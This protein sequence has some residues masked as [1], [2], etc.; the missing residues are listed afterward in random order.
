MPG[1]A[2]HLREIILFSGVYPL[3]RCAV[4]KKRKKNLSNAMC[5]VIIKGAIVVK[6]VELFRKLS[7]LFFPLNY[8]HIH[9][10]K[11]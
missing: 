3:D 5:G 8:E 4:I 7:F 1:A 6:R 2:A 10:A 11:F 9:T